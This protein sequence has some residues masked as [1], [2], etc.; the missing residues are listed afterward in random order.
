MDWTPL[1]LKNLAALFNDMADAVL[2][3]RKQNGATLSDAETLQLTTQF[4]QLI[5]SA[6]T[7]EHL[8]VAGVL[9]GIATDVKDLQSASHGAIA[10]LK[11]I[12][13]V[14]KIVTIAIAAVALGA[15]IAAPTPGTIAAAL[16]VLVQGVTDATAPPAVPTAAKP[17]TP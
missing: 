4:G 8:A 10:A 2:A 11:T 17:S 1:D 12:S 15:A 7:M 3:Y 16:S 6:E 13:D 14:Q 9:P 5:S